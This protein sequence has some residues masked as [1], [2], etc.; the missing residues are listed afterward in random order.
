ML[1]SS[2]LYSDPNGVIEV[3]IDELGFDDDEKFANALGLPIKTVDQLR[4]KAIK[5][6]PRLLLQMLEIS[7]FSTSELRNLVVARRTR[8]H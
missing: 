3:L 2:E 4:R 5:L 7:E 8:Y 6:E 1:P